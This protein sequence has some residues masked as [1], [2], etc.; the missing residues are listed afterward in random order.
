MTALAPATSSYLHEWVVYYGVHRV[1]RLDGGQPAQADGGDAAVH[2]EA[3]PE[4]EGG[5]RAGG[6]FM[7]AQN[8][9]SLGG[10]AVWPWLGVFI[11]DTAEE[12]ESH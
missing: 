11:L 3:D 4:E 7:T 10:A 8:R 1:A 9:S 12:S 5:G 6:V 2:T